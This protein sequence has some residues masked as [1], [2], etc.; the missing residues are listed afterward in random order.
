MAVKGTDS[1]SSGLDS[2]TRTQVNGVPLSVL[3]LSDIVVI[4]IFIT[5]LSCG[6]ALGRIRR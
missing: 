4:P 2:L 3:N 5:G 1:A 6:L